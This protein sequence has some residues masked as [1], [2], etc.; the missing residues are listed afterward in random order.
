LL[1]AITSELLPPVDLIDDVDGTFSGV[2]AS[3]VEPGEGWVG[4]DENLLI[5]SAPGYLI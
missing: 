3:T 5:R 4:V 2:D 1:L